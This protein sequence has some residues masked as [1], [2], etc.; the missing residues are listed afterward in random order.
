[1]N[2]AAPAPQAPLPDWTGLSLDVFLQGPQMLIEFLRL[3]L[4]SL[5]FFAAGIVSPESVAAA[6]TE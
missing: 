6:P 4:R 5:A 3:S 1:M 2:S